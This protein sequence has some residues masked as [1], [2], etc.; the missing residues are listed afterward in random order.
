MWKRC[1]KSF[2][3][4]AFAGMLVNLIIEIIVRAVSGFDYSPVTPEFI[5]FFPSASIAYSVDAL[6]YGVIGLTYALMMFIFGC[7]RIGFV[8][9]SII[10]YIPTGIVCIPIIIFIWRLDKYP[11]ALISTIIGFIVTDIVMTVISYKITK[12]NIASINAAIDNQ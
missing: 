7:D 11:S 9:Q 12:K 8:I 5:A 1:I 10:Y 6:L 2:I 4:S 3:Y